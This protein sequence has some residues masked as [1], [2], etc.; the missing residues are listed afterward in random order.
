MNSQKNW[1]KETVKLI[2]AEKPS[3]AK[4]YAAA[5]GV[6]ERKDGY[7]A[8]E[9][10]LISWCIGHLAGLA[11][12]GMYDPKFHDW[13]QEDLPIIPKV[14]QAIIHSDKKK[15]FDTLRALMARD[16]VA[17]IVNACDA[18]RE[19]ELIFRNV[20]LLSGCQKPVRRLWL[21]SMEDEA[22]RQGFQQLR[23]G[24]EYEGL[25]QSA[26]CRAKADW[27]VGINA[28]RFFSLLYHHK[29][30]VGRVM[31]PTLAMIVQREA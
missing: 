27:L 12:A 5:L 30:K 3:V 28:T 2:I 1:R 8:G 25:Y 23:D 22:I 16:D 4:T 10:Y 14:W 6:K 11:D 13:R 15:Q 19:G 9:T 29:L 18:G 20:Y 26:L 24:S 7:F 17:E 21:S 31:S